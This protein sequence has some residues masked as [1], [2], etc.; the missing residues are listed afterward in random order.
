MSFL[1]MHLEFTSKTPCNANKIESQNE[2]TTVQIFI[3]K[4]SHRKSSIIIYLNKRV[5]IIWQNT[6][7]AFTG[8][9]TTKEDGMHTCSSMARVCCLVVA[10][11]VFVFARVLDLCAN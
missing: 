10:N 3:L 9:R 8:L 7:R 1:Q 4:G 11:S 5:H 2:A 6:K